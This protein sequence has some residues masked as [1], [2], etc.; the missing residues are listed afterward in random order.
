MVD[1]RAV[2]QFYDRWAG[3]YD[4]LARAPVVR[5]WRRQ[6][7]DSL[8]L[9]P[10]AVVVEMGC[11]TG[12]NL[13]LLRERVGPDGRVVGVD[14]T[15]GMVARARQRL[16][17]AG[18]ENVDLVGETH[19]I[20]R[21]CA[22]STPCWRRSS[23]G[24]SNDRRPSSRSGRSSSR[25]CRITLLDATPS[26]RPIARPVNLLF[27]AFTR[28]SAPSSR[29]DVASPARRLADD[30]EAAH[31]RLT[32]V[33]TDSRRATFGLGYLHLAAGRRV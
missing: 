24:W 23:S 21:S 5:G 31:G 8:A 7:V 22:M 32:S 13:P 2:R 33:T 11:G 6:A 10:G 18:W 15:G 26:S 20:H 14:L 12:A 17:R 30:V 9:S 27:R 3:P 29:T 25:N 28:L 1:E 16:D 4:W 19:A